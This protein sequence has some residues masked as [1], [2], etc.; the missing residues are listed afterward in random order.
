M[1]R[2]SREIEDVRSSK[3]SKYLVRICHVNK[4]IELPT[5]PWIRVIRI[6][7]VTIELLQLIRGNDKGVSRRIILNLLKLAIIIRSRSE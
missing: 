2:N 6:M 7:S 3:M 4:Q 1:S 5:L